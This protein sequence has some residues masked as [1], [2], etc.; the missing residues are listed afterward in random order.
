MY[1]GEAVEEELSNLSYYTQHTSIILAIGGG[2][3]WDNFLSDQKCKE[4]QQ[5]EKS[6]YNLTLQQDLYL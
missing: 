1:I 4:K 6:I 5:L 3:L 2:D